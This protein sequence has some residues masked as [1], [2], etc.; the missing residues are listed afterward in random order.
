MPIDDT[1]VIPDHVVR[2][3]C[4]GQRSFLALR[5]V[6]GLLYALDN[7]VRGKMALVPARFP[8]EH[9]ARTS[10]FAAAVGPEKAKDNRWIHEA[11]AE[12][13]ELLPICW[14]GSGAF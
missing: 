5:L 11:C 1:Y 14:T 2:F 10:V 13:A 9:S 4:D 6:H 7:A 8:G 3:L 12:L